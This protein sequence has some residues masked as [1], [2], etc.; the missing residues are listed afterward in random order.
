MASVWTINIFVIL[1]VC[2]HRNNAQVTHTFI[3]TDILAWAYITCITFVVLYNTQRTLNVSLNVPWPVTQLP[4]YTLWRFV[5]SLCSNNVYFHVT[6]QWR[7][8]AVEHLCQGDSLPV[9]KL[10]QWNL[11]F[12]TC[13]YCAGHLVSSHW[14]ICCV[15]LGHKFYHFRVLIWINAQ[16]CVNSHPKEFW[17]V[18]YTKA[19]ISTWHAV[20]WIVVL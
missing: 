7:L 13:M 3:Y 5:W 1:T 14:N 18:F 17:Y 6:R 2:V 4:V 8:R 11:N 16:Q 20:A 15:C 10:F 12:F 9:G 19:S